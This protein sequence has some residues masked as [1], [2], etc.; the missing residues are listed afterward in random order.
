MTFFE[1]V[2]TQIKNIPY[3]KVATYGQIAAL[4][5]G[6]RG[7]RT[8][9]WILRQEELFHPGLLPW[10]RVINSQGM[11]SIEN[12]GVTKLE[13]AKRLQAEGIAVEFKNGN[14]WV[15]LEKYLWGEIPNPKHQIPIN[16]KCARD[17]AFAFICLPWL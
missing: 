3:G 13:Q 6:P 8:V 16:K 1:R 9:G 12:F 2:K 10:H 11:I 5:G 4:A 7:A 15:D 17:S 14:Y